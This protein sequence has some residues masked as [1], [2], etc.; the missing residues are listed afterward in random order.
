MAWR[1]VKLPDRVIERV[2]ALA[3]ECGRSRAR[4]VEMLLDGPAGP[5]DVDEPSHDEAVRL[6]AQMARAGKVGAAVALERA[7]R[8]SGDQSAI[9]DDPLDELR[10][11][12]PARGEH[13]A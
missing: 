3:G 7:L 5:G 9:E 10:Q 12:R 4:T 2:D 13:V 11:R 8:A 1:T 6:L